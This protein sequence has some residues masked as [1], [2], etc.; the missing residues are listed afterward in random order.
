[1]VIQ[2]ENGEIDV[3]SQGGFAQMG[4]IGMHSGNPT[5][6]MRD[7]SGRVACKGAICTHQYITMHVGVLSRKIFLL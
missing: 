5:Y 7:P 6:H 3:K 1:M 4:N 2:V